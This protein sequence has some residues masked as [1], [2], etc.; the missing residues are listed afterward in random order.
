MSATAV[1]ESG[2]LGPQ[3]A[4]PA[5]VKTFFIWMGLNLLGIPLGG[6]LG[7]AVAGRVD[8]A[9]PALLGGALTGA[10]IGLAQWVMLRRS[11][12]VGV[13]WIVAT[14]LG[15]G[16]GLALGAVAVGYETSMGQIAIMGAISGAG[17]G[18]AQ[19]M[20][21][22][23]RFSLWHVWMIAMPA[24]WALGWVVADAAVIDAAKQFTVFG[25]SGAVAFAILS[26]P[27]LT[28]GTR[29]EKSATV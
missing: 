23:R 3:L 5:G 24:L 1:T 29:R 7:Y 13:E 15:L 16:A 21:L 26:A 28:A 11:L 25:A 8:D 2:R 18:I 6:Y 12:G 14:S 4:R 22:R 9:V 19:G 10:G 20:L 17:V 27:L